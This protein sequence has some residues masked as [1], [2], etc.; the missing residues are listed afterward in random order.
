MPGGAKCQ[1]FSDLTRYQETPPQ[2]FSYSLKE[3]AGL[4]SRALR[5][6]RHPRHTMADVARHPAWVAVWLLVLIVWALCGAWLLSTAV[7]R[8][9]LIDERV[10][11]VEAF[12]GEMDDT[13]YAALQA[14]PP[15][16]VYLLSGSRLLLAPPITLLVAAAI[17]YPVRVQGGNVSWQ[18][19][20]AVAVHASVVLAVG[21]VV[22]TPIHY[23]R[24]SL[25]S[26]LNLA[27]IVRV[28]DEGSLLGRILSS[29]DLFTLWWAWLLAL[30]MAT[31]ANASSRR[32]SV[33]VFAVYGSVAIIL[34]V[35]QGLSGGH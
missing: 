4:V 32:W 30:G 18:Q 33:R 35:V 29:M 2:P 20:L 8:Q 6:L 25:T 22:A 21:Q 16:M 7:G 19:A 14:R 27:T 10:R 12:G 5:V 31:L 9:A 11:V 15:W 26:P 34:A 24:E 1:R 13:T 17:Y 3:E 28:A 23:I